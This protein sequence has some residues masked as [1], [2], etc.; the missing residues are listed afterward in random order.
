MADSEFDCCQ[1]RAV[2]WDN[3][4]TNC[5]GLVLL[6]CDYP[7]AGTKPP[8]S[9]ATSPA[10]AAAA[11]W[12]NAD[13]AGPDAIAAAAAAMPELA[14]VRHYLAAARGFEVSCLCVEVWCGRLHATARG[15][16]VKVCSPNQVGLWDHVVGSC[17]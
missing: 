14:A 1:P 2:F 13:V 12:A 6:C 11:A 17:V 15:G 10:A 3:A 9:A 5:A 16:G 8:S 7:H 4:A